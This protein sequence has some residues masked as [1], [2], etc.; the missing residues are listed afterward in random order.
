VSSISERVAAG[1]AWLDEHRPGWVDR[2]DLETLNLG[3]PCRCLLAQDFGEHF[4]DAV[5]AA[6]LG[7]GLSPSA[8]GF[9]VTYARGD[10]G[11]MWPTER[12]FDALTAAWRDLI[13]QR[14]AEVSNAD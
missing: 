8:I 6:G 12:E 5:L 3:D 11:F 4:S 2:I 1:A 7:Q 9:N 14:R 10:E 13:R